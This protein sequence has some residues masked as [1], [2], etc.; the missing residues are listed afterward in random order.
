MRY[1]VQI[2]IL[3][4]WSYNIFFY[5]EPKYHSTISIGNLSN[6]ETDEKILLKTTVFEGMHG[7]RFSAPFDKEVYII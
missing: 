3:R 5:E 1:T 7:S 6:N 2:E 4:N